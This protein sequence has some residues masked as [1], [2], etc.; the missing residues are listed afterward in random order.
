MDG[1][2][3]KGPPLDLDKL[4]PPPSG[5]GVHPPPERVR[6]CTGKATP[7]A[8]LI[9]DLLNPCVPK[10]EMAHAA[11]REIAELTRML[12]QCS[13]WL[14]LVVE[15]CIDDEDDEESILDLVG[16][17]SKKLGGPGTT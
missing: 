14:E 10:N 4:V 9:A 12:G 16:R 15:T 13:V 5:T 6:C 3:P 8:E 7:H 17:V 1:H 11:A 2:Q